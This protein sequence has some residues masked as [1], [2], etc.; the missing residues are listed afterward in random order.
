MSQP[1]GLL[2]DLLPGELGVLIAEHGEQAYRGRQLA[3]WLYRSGALDWAEMTDLPLRLRQRLAA[4]H[5]LQ[6]LTPVE[7]KVAADGTR[8]LL[9]QLQDGECIESVLIPM[10][11]HVTFCLSS[12]VGCTMACRFCATAR[13]G[14][15]RQL[16]SGEILE[17]IFHLQR[18]LVR[19]PPPETADRAFNL[20]FMGMGEPLDNWVQ[21]DRAVKALTDPAG[22]A[23]SP[24]RITLST[25]GRPDVLSGWLRRPPAIGLTISLAGAEDALRRR[26]MPVA[27][28]TP[29]RRLLDLAEAYSRLIRRRVT[30]A[31][32]LI[33]DQT[34]DPAQAHH[35]ARLARRRPFKVNLLPLNEL[36]G[37]PLA[38]PSAGRIQQFLEILIAAG[39]P[40]TVRQSGGTEIDAACGQL[41]ARRRRAP[42]DERRTTRK[43]EG[44]DR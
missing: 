29:L 17:Q 37:Q 39:V 43:G 34:D 44:P 31:Y 19:E 3:H 2:R 15:R 38:P 20:V 16:T 26:L 25:S 7:R 21:V 5:A 33:A 1:R 36:E 14:L 6:G 11:G 9:C 30:L 27:G 40:A 41:R 10:A 28:R 35:L 13:G 12:Q 42:S 4:D 18:D 24:R 32:V 23:I 22:A 8:K